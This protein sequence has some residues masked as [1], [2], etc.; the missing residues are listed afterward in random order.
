MNKHIEGGNIAFKSEQGA[1][2]LLNIGGNVT[3]D[4]KVDK[5]YTTDPFD[6]SHEKRKLFEWL[7]VG[8]VTEL[9]N[10]GNSHTIPYGNTMIYKG[11][12]Q[13]DRLEFNPNNGNIIRESSRTYLPGTYS[14]SDN[15]PNHLTYSWFGSFFEKHLVLDDGVA[16]TDD[17]GYSSKLNINWDTKGKIRF[18]KY[19]AKLAIG[20]DDGDVKKSIVKDLEF[21]VIPWKLITIV[22][23]IILAYGYHKLRDNQK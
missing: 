15:K 19:Q 7:P 17:D 1:I 5:F 4:L 6:N 22:I 2:I 13:I 18:G 9:K 21:W 3:R 14:E 10:T 11:D 20:Y 16:Q 12:K 23:L 8:F